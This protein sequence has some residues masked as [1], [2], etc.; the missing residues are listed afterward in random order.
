MPQSQMTLYFAP[1]ACSLASHILAEEE[2]LP[3]T[4][5]QVDLKSHKTMSGADYRRINPKGY[6]PALKLED[7]TVLTENVALLQFLADLK[8]EKGLAPARP[9]MARVHLE[10]WLAYISSELHKAFAPIFHNKGENEQKDAKR[11]IE[12]R[13]AYAETQLAKGKFLLGDGFT[14]ADAYLFVMLT[15]CDKAKIDLGKFPHLSEYRER[16]KAR[17]AVRTA[18][19]AE[20]LV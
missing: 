1:G 20:G 4:Y 8:P 3:I 16:M 11:E 13:L 5:E 10:E 7:G 18:M 14:A 9:S 6:V 15:W 12:T 2:G 17:P 19:A